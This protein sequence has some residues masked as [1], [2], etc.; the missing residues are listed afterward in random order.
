MTACRGGGSF[1]SLFIRL[2]Y[3]L[4]IFSPF[5]YIMHLAY[6]SLQRR[7]SYALLQFLFTMVSLHS[8]YYVITA[9]SLL[10]YSRAESGFTVS[11]YP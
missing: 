8:Q 5:F 6:V 2:S 1:M 11:W 9:F 7:I 4:S 3:M 10:N